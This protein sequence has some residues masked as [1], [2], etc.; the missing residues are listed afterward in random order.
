MRNELQLLRRAPQGRSSQAGRGGGGTVLWDK[1]VAALVVK[2]T[3]FTGLENDPVDV[4]AIQRCG[5]SI[6]KRIHDLDD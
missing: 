3:H 1:N 2:R 4:K 5:A 6:H